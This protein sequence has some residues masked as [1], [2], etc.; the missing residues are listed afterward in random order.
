MMLGGGEGGDILGHALTEP[1]ALSTVLR[2]RRVARS[3]R[4]VANRWKLGMA[5]SLPWHA[6]SLAHLTVGAF[7]AVVVRSPAVGGA[8]PLLVGLACGF[9]LLLLCLPLFADFFELY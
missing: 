4:L 7:G 2:T 5:R 8:L 1:W 9:L 6:N 3:S